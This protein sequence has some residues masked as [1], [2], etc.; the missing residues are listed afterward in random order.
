MMMLWTCIK[1][2]S[3]PDINLNT[4]VQLKPGPRMK[5]ISG[6]ISIIKAFIH[7]ATSLLPNPDKIL[8]KV[9]EVL[10]KIMGFKPSSEYY[11]MGSSLG[12]KSKSME[13]IVEAR[14][15]LKLQRILVENKVLQTR[16]NGRSFTFYS[17]S[18][19]RF[20]K[21]HKERYLAYKAKYCQ[22]SM[23]KTELVTIK[24]SDEI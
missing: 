11:E 1:H 14:Q 15:F 3:D 7:L 5:S 10:L 18:R 20:L 22:S 21:Y 24:E 16:S 23:M 2:D 12:R 4:S 9:S 17:N 8:R 13:K 19:I 6:N